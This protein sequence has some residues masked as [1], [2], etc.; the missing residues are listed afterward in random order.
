M[1]DLI[2]LYVMQTP[3]AA[4]LRHHIIVQQILPKYQTIQEEK[5]SPVQ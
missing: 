5:I 2:T 3:F 1:I 4:W